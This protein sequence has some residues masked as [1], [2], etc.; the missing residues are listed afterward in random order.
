MTSNTAAITAG[1]VEILFFEVG[2]C[3]YGADAAQVLRVDRPRAEIPS[4]ASLGSAREGTRALIFATASGAIN[5]LQ[6]DVVH[7][8][9]AI[10][11]LQLRRLPV[12]TSPEGFALGVWLDGDTPVL[13]VNLAEIAK[14][15][16]GNGG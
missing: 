3:R 1:E 13:L 12:G 4:V 16:E 6:V 14:R 5:Q 9:R 15:S 2:G 8:V 7:G 11:I 10:P